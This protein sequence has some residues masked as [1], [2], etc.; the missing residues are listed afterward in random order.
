M[1]TATGSSWQ[2]VHA[3]LGRRIRERE[4]RPGELVPAET[5]L[6]RELGCARSTVNRAMRELVDS[7]LV[8][9]RRRAGTRVVETPVRRASFEIPVIR[10]E[11]ERRGARW[12]YRLLLREKALPP[13][14][15]ASRLR[16]APRRTALHV[17]SLHLA[18]HQPF[19]AEDRW[20]SVEVVPGIE[21]VDLATVSANEW[22]VRNAPFTGGTFDL[23]AANA[24]PDDARLLGVEP[25][26]ALLV[27]ERTTFDG[28]RPITTVRLAYAPGYRIRSRV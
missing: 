10:E 9:R 1:S 16:L 23:S 13:V 25:G 21:K 12:D 20:I 18:D 17:R 11:V 14:A 27:V 3:E 6:A 22:L 2:A 19:L 26:T 7:G 24:G 15:I 8:E 4:W 5:E 28:A